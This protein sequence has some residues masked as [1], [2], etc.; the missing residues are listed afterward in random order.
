M[1]PYFAARL[2]HFMRKGKS[3]PENDVVI[4]WLLS[5]H[6]EFSYFMVHISLYM[7]YILGCSFF[8]NKM[9]TTWKIFE[10]IWVSSAL[11]IV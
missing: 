7:C 9:E 4:M 10:G 8:K 3:S 1:I 6:E 2:L 11:N 5:W